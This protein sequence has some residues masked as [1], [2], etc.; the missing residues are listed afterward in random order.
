MKIYLLQMGRIAA[1]DMNVPTFAE[2]PDISWPFT[3]ISDSQLMNRDATI[4]ILSV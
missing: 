1:A 4:G 2:T 3:S